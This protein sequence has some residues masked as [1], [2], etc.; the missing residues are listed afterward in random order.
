[1]FP[2][3]SSVTEN[4][5]FCVSWALITS[6]IHWVMRKSHWISYVRQD[7]WVLVLNIATG[8]AITAGYFK[9]IEIYWFQQAFLICHTQNMFHCW[10]FLKPIQT[11][12]LWSQI[13]QPGKHPPVT[14]DCDYKYCCRPTVLL[15]NMLQGSMQTVSQVPQPT[16]YLA[17]G[18]PD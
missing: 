18:E 13:L 8:N 1:M 17:V 14:V 5:F 2:Q 7:R 16:C 3:I 15:R 10:S 11:H 12:W 4:M 9:P 6:T